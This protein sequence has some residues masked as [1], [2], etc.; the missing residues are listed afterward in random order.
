MSIALGAGVDRP[1]ISIGAIV[2]DTLNVISHRF[3]TLA[4][5]ALCF[6]T[7]PQAMF[8]LLPK[9]LA[10]LSLAA[11]LPALVFNGGAVLIAVRHLSGRPPLS[12]GEAIGAGARRFG[13][14]WAM[15]F[16]SGLGTL[17]GL[18]LLLV[19]GLFLIVAWM[20]ATAALISEDLS[21]TES[22][23]RAWRLTDGCRWSVAGVLAILFAAIMVIL[24]AFVFVVAFFAIGL[25]QDQATTI[26]SVALAPLMQSVL[27]ILAVVTGAVVYFHLRVAK[28]GAADV[29]TIFA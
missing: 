20:P 5:L 11:G 22:L 19:P 14:L 8:G 27:D 15:G 23:S 6:L 3:L 24:I 13:S 9:D 10:A 12:L 28:E 4:L 29:S 21:S 25:G 1:V 18:L 7:L 16:F 17:A 26:S 2:K